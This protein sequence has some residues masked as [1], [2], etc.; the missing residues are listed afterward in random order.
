MHTREQPLQLL[1]LKQLF[2]K[3]IRLLCRCDLNGVK[4]V[5]GTDFTATNGS[6]VVLASGATV[7]DNVEILAYVGFNVA[8]ALT[9]ANNLSDV[10]RPQQ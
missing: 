7:G 10:R 8:N 4:L 1:H 5:V 2:Q 3:H 9:A 6:S